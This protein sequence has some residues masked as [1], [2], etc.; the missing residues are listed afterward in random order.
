MADSRAMPMPAELESCLESFEA[1][2]QRNEV[3]SL[4]ETL[5]ATT[6]KNADER[7]SLLSELVLIDLEYRWRVAESLLTD[8][9]GPRPRIVDYAK[10]LASVDSFN[11]LPVALVAEEYRVRQLWGDR[12]SLDHFLAEYPTHLAELV[13]RLQQIDRELFADGVR[14]PTVRGPWHPTKPSKAAPLRFDDYLLKQLIGAGGAGRVYRAVQRSTGQNVA[15]KA[16]RKSLQF[17]SVAVKQ[18]VQEAQI[19]QQL[20]HPHIV[21]VHGLGRFPAGGHFLVMDFVEGEDLASFLSQRSIEI[22]DTLRMMKQITSAVQ[23][24]HEQ[25]VIH[26]DLKPANVLR[27]SEGDVLVTDFGMAQLLSQV[28]HQPGG[29]G[30]TAGFMAPEQRGEKQGEISPATDV[31]GL[32]GLLRELLAAASGDATADG[33]LSAICDRCLKPDPRNR[34][35]NIAEMAKDLGRVR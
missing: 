8:S 13:G 10:Q 32:G 7:S 21:R 11:A 3:P 18:F 35:S 1:A 5:K 29:V 4:R 12:P 22:S 26:C 23:Y 31:Y 20:D 17:D 25:G 30:G 2:W 27:D 33:D 24:A 14:E 15:V 16:L 28:R 34:Y 9:L 6:Q 19:V